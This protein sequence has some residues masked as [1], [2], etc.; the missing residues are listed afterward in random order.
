MA[1]PSLYRAL[2]QARRIALMT[3]LLTERKEARAVYASRMSKRGGFRAVTL[4]LW[5]AAKLAQEVVRMNAQTADDE[6]DLLQTLYVDFEPAIQAD[7]LAAA[8]V[9]ADGAVIDE[10]IEPPYCDE[11]AVLRAAAVIREKHGDDAVHY[12]RVIGRYN[13]VGWPG[14]ET[15]LAGLPASG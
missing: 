2:P 12:L 4:S 6:V 1:N 15:V 14:I 10:S 3:R 13:P 5:P 8:G 11:S 9:K 7:F